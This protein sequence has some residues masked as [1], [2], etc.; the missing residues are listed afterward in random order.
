[1][2][3]RVV[4]TEL[5]AGIC[6]SLCRAGMT[7]AI[8]IDIAHQEWQVLAGQEFST[9]VASTVSQLDVASSKQAQKLNINQL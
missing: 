1:M 2:W 7:P 4:Q 9:A 3:D 8:R 5:K 6:C